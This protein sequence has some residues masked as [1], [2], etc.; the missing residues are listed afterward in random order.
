MICWH[1]L[2]LSCFWWNIYTICEEMSVPKCSPRKS[3]CKHQVTGHTP[4]RV[5]DPR[6]RKFQKRL[7]QS[8]YRLHINDECP[9]PFGS[10]HSR[11]PAAVVQYSIWISCMYMV[12]EQILFW[13][14]QQHRIHPSTSFVSP[15]FLFIYYLSFSYIAYPYD[16]TCVA[17][18][19]CCSL[20]SIL[21]SYLSRGVV[22]VTVSCL[23]LCD[24][25]SRVSQY[26]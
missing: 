17:C 25:L 7:R 8:T 18:R 10:W 19:C 13:A 2:H 26:E 15:D 16:M 9:P 24:H 5:S 20:T 14:H 22:W 1:E 3:E 23:L 12:R 6:L 21:A 4:S 11:A